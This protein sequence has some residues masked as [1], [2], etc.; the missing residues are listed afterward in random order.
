MQAP[1][2]ILGYLPHG[3]PPRGPAAIGGRG[4]GRIDE[5]RFVVDPIPLGKSQRLFGDGTTSTRLEPKEVNAYPSGNIM[6][7]Y[8]RPT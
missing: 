7:R 5:Y 1:G 2:P 4:P 3:V 8:A 6:L